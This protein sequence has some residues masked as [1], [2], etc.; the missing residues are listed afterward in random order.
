MPVSLIVDQNLFKTVRSGAAINNDSIPGLISIPDD[1]RFDSRGAQHVVFYWAATGAGAVTIDVTIY[2]W[3]GMDG[4]I[5]PRF[6]VGDKLSGL[7]QNTL[8]SIQCLGASQ[9]VLAISGLGAP[10]GTAFEIRAMGITL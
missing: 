5:T 3:D 8:A 7:A 9:A 4:V 6:V 10:A 1:Q 2:I